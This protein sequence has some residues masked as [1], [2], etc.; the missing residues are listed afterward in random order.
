MADGQMSRDH[1]ERAERWKRNPPKGMTIEELLRRVDDGIA[2]RRE[3]GELPPADL[4]PAKP[5]PDSP[6]MNKRQRKRVIQAS[7]L[8]IYAL[9]NGDRDDYCGAIDVINATRR[10]AGF[11]TRFMQ[12]IC[13]GIADV[14]AEC[15]GERRDV[16]D[17]IAR[18]W[19]DEHL[20]G[21]GKTI[22][23]PKGG[24][25]GGNDETKH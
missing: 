19:L 20:N 16:V 4:T 11:P 13:D 21:A 5:D 9:A 17:Q 23:I 7:D 2:K 18:T 24:T 6:H 8:A 1:D 14:A 3:R 10:Q 15:M 12:S 22:S 25:D